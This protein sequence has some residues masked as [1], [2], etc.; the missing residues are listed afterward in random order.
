[1]YAYTDD[2]LKDLI[3]TVLANK[4]ANTE[5]KEENLDLQNYLVATPQQIRLM[6]CGN[7]RNQ[8]SQ[9]LAVGLELGIVNVS[10]VDAATGYD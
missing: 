10:Q 4:K 7:E 8:I 3:F 1:M 6:F 2:S 9:I 5:L